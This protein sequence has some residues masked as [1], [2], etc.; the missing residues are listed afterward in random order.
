MISAKTLFGNIIALEAKNEEEFEIKYKENYI[1]ESYRPFISVKF[2][3]EDQTYNDLKNIIINIHDMLPFIENK[4]KISIDQNYN[5]K[6]FENL[7]LNPNPKSVKLIEDLSKFYQNDDY[8]FLI[9]QNT[10]CIHL[11]KQYIDEN[12]TI[13]YQPDQMFLMHIA[14]NINN[15]ALDILFTFNKEQFID[16]IWMELCYNS[17]PKAFNKIL[18]NMQYITEKEN[19]KNILFFLNLC[20]NTEVIKYLEQHYELINWIY[21]SENPIAIDLLLKNKEKIYFPHLCKNRHPEAVKIIFNIIKQEGFDSSKIDYFNL[22]QNKSTIMIKFIE[23]NFDK[24][25]RKQIINHKDLIFKNSSALFFIEKLYKKGYK[26]PNCIWSNE[27]IF[28]N[29]ND[30]IYI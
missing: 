25:D 30:D 16:E 17:N 21:L 29:D 12:K 15:E 5:N 23:D 7:V 28:K 10:N 22:F 4:Y 26:I 9:F 3:G 24:I 13:Y 11:I 18:E 6:I 27:S 19:Y 2:F 14:K 1:K 8:R 20:E